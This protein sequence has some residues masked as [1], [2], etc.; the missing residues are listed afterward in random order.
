MQPGLLRRIERHREV[1]EKLCKLVR[2]LRGRLAR[3]AL[4]LYGSY[5]RGDFNA[6]S[7]VDV[8]LVWEG[9]G[10]KR[11]PERYAVLRD[12][13][14]SI[15]EPLELI[16]WTPREAK[17]MLGKPTWRKALQDC[18]VFADDYGIF[19]GLCRRAEC[20]GERRREPQNGRS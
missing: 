13:L 17:L 6:W 9:F 7:D 5:A 18:V 16:P 8:I 4:V 12:V 1:L 2:L 10:S 20:D 3:L 14:S 15:D 11:L 19:T